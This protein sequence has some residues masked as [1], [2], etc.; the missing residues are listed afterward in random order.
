MDLTKR[1]QILG[2]MMQPGDGGL[3][4]LPCEID[5]ADGQGQSDEREQSGPAPFAAGP[6]AGG[7][8]RAQPKNLVGI[9]DNLAGPAV[10]R[11]ES[12]RLSVFHHLDSFLGSVI[13]HRYACSHAPAVNTGRL[14]LAGSQDLALD[15]RRPDRRFFPRRPN[16]RFYQT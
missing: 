13:R 15:L 14:R 10:A 3:R 6:Y 9:L 2:L 4:R 12:R 11:G 1:N 7:V 5:E 8:E 16:R